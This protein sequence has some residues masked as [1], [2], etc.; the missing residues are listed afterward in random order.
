MTSSSS[1]SQTIGRLRERLVRKVDE[2]QTEIDVLDRLELHLGEQ[3]PDLAA[4]LV[5]V[6]TMPLYKTNASVAITA[7]SRAEAVEVLRQFEG[8]LLPLAFSKGTFARIAPADST[9]EGESR[10]E[11]DILP[12]FWVM[13]GHRASHRPDVEAP[14]TLRAYADLS[15][16]TRVE[17]KIKIKGDP[18]KAKAQR[19]GVAHNARIIYYELS[20][21]PN[22]RVVR[23]SGGGSQSL[24]DTY[25]YFGTESA[26]GDQKKL[27]DELAS[28]LATTQ[29]LRRDV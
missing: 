19:R 25:V 23:F 18:A 29:F 28:A 8:K 22:G 12:A 14:A 21:L 10:V 5:H 4:D 6:R 1:L 20:E 9:P 7:G 27:L 15:P 17:L 3:A 2:A 13:D 24:G 26:G 16:N 11:Q